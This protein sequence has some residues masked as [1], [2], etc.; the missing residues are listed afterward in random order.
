MREG[1]FDLR[2]V[3]KAPFK[4]YLMQYF[5]EAFKPLGQDPLRTSA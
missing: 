1:R 4:S 2:V 3:I 5:P